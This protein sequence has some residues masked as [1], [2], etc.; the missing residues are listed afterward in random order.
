MPRGKR[1]KA[2]QIIPKL[3]KVEVEAPGREDAC[4]SFADRLMLGVNILLWPVLC[5]CRLCGAL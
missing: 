2:E 4:E 3:R 5:C 1:V